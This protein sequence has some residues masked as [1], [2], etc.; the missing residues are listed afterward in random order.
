MFGTSTKDGVESSLPGEVVVKRGYG[1]CQDFSGKL[2]R[3]KAAE[4]QES[5][6]DRLRNR[7]G[8][9]GVPTMWYF[10]AVV[11]MKSPKSLNEAIHVEYLSLGPV[12]TTEGD[13]LE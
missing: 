1:G 9:H 6:H 7:G 10:E 4:D 11:T 12:G 13:L 8:R 2:P 3:V 5:R